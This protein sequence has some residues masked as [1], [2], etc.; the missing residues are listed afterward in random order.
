MLHDQSRPFGDCAGHDNLCIHSK[1]E[2]L[3]GTPRLT[4]K[5]N[6]KTFKAAART[7]DIIIWN[8]E[9]QQYLTGIGVEWVLILRKPPKSCALQTA[10]SVLS[11]AWP[12]CRFLLN[13]LLTERSS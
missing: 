13:C 5:D 12:W 9:V 8:S 10:W 7:I 6:G 11:L 3:L 2:A 4:K 1:P